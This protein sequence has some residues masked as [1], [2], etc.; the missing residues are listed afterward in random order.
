MHLPNESVLNRL[1]RAAQARRST[2][3]IPIYVTIF[4]SFAIF[5]R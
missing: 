3:L 2:A 1:D 5:R 4:F